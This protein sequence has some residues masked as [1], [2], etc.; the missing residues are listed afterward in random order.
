VVFVL[1]FPFSQNLSFYF[2][3]A[4]I[5]MLVF[6]G[7]RLLV[8]NKKENWVFSVHAHPCFLH[9]HF[10]P[11]QSV[12]RHGFMPFLIGVVHGLA[13]SGAILAF[14][15]AGIGSALYGFSFL[16]FFGTGL[17][18][19]MGSA[20]AALAFMAGKTVSLQSHWFHSIS[21]LAG[22]FSILVALHLAYQLVF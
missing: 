14:W 1:G 8:K 21:F 13:G 9:A 6:L 2:E 20:S 5:V 22:L 19:A 15:V 11:T 12:H 16:L 7:A 4:V 3:V 18:V 17:V 10:T